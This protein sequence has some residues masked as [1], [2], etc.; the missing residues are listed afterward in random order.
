MR[1]TEKGKRIY[2]VPRRMSGTPQLDA[3]NEFRCL[4]YNKLSELEDIEDQLGI[5]LVTLFKA[6][7]NGIYYTRY[8]RGTINYCDKPRLIP[9]YTYTLFPN[10]QVEKEISDYDFVVSKKGL[11]LSV[12]TYKKYWALTKEEL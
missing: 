5:D 2:P 1:L 9:C 8:G 6:F 3:E 4:I 12:K 11:T 7:N 10:G